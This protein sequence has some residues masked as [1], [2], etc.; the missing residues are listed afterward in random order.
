MVE[1]NPDH[2]ELVRILLS[3]SPD[4]VWRFERAEGLKE[5]LQLLS[6]RA[7]DLVLLDLNLPD[8]RGMETVAR[9]RAQVPETPVVVATVDDDE[10]LGIEAIQKGVQDYIVKGTLG[11]EEL[12]RALVLAIERKKSQVATAHL[13]A[14][15][16][17]SQDAIVSASLEG[18]ILTWN[19][20]AERICGYASADVVGRPFEMLFPAGHEEF[21]QKI[22]QQLQAGEPIDPFDTVALRKDGA[23]V[24]VSLSLAPIREPIAPTRRPRPEPKVTGMVAVAR[25]ISQR[26]RDEEALRHREEQYRLLFD[27]N[28]QP[29]WV[30]DGDSLRF[31]AVNDAAIRHYGYSREEFLSMTL[32]DIRPPDEIAAFDEQVRRRRRQPERKPFNLLQAWKHRRKDG[33]IVEVEVSVSAIRFEERDAWLALAIDVTEKKRL[34]GQLLQAQKM[35]SVGRLA[36]GIAHD[37]NNL[38]GVITGYGELAR[39]QLAAGSPVRGRLDEMLKATARAADLTKQLL[40]FSRKQVLQPRVVNLNMVTADMERMLRRLIGEHIQLM[41]VY[42]DELGHVRADPG[43]VGQVIVNLAINA[44]DAMPGGGRLMVETANA[45]LDEAYAAGRP[46]VEP[47]RYVMLSVTDTGVGM[48]PETL[49]RIFEPF[50]TTKAEGHGTGLG[51]ATAYGIVRQSGGHIWTY[52]EPGKGTTFRIYLPRVD[53]A[54]QPPAPRSEGTATVR[55]SETIL[56]VEDDEAL[57]AII[58]EVLEDAGYSV[59]TARNGDE[60]IGAAAE[61]RLIDLVISDMVMPAM[62][63]AVLAR[64]L[65]HLRFLFM[66]GYTELSVAEDGGLTRGAAFLEKPF[67]PGALLRKVRGVLDG[68]AT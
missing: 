26:K 15:V 24:Y 7:V 29:M 6:V 10:A 17:H 54:A 45:D 44:R 49:A 33:S 43:Q 20:A 63:G 2:A 30:Y 22:R 46:D 41:T 60:A 31:L 55:G 62:G 52:S 48:T 38:L 14:V 35:E 25:D 51:L 34:E 40:A 57:R 37:F 3:K 68:N 36:G 16:D 11:P 64:H 42:A 66:S 39:R 58:A 9:V 1:D 13:A 56:V 61:P 53:E 21:I 65:P 50:F 4:H 5:A 67:T 27:T 32:R 47:G 23:R 8:S 59:L 28:P 19:P 12:S 18:T